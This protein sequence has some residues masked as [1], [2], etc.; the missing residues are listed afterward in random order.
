M[1]TYYFDHEHLDAYR[2]SLDVAH[3]VA[4]TDFPRGF[5]PLKDQAVRAAQ[6]VVMNLAEGKSRGG[7]AGRNHYRIALG[8]AAEVC[9]ALD[10]LGSAAAAEQ[11][12][13]LRRVG[14]MLRGLTR[15]HPP[16]P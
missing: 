11:Q 10:L 4:S 3:W 13:K 1:H 7:D 2:L 8:S 16:A 6:S 9:A 15:Q 5:A 14:A 12:A